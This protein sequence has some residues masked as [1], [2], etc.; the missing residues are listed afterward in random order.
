MRN[1]GLMYDPKKEEINGIPEEMEFLPA[2]NQKKLEKRSPKERMLLVGVIIGAALLSLVTGLLVWHFHFRP[3][4]RIK[5]MYN[6]YLTIA[7]KQFTEE[8]EDSESA[9]FKKLAAT[10][11]KTLQNT[12]MEMDSVA[13]Y[14][15][16]STVTAFSEGSVIAYY[17]LECRV[18]PENADE[19]DKAIRATSQSISGRSYSGVSKSL[20]IAELVV[21]RADPQ[22]VKPPKDK[23]CFFDLHAFPEEVSTFTSPGFPNS[24][25]PANSWCQWVIRADPNHILELKFVTFDLENICHNDFVVVYDSLSPIEKREITERCGVYPPTNALKLISSRNVMLVTLM[26]DDDENYPGFK[27][28]F[29]QLP[30]RGECNEILEGSGNISSPYYPAYYPPRADCTWTLRVPSNKHVKVIFEVFLLQ[31]PDKD[32]TCKDYVEI[33]GKK[34]CGEKPKMVELGNKNE[35]TVR[36]RSDA[37]GSFRGFFA[38]F[39]PHDPSKPCPK[40]FACNNGQCIQLDLKCDGWNDCGDNSDEIGCVCT[41]EQFLCGTGLCK[42]K[43]WVCDGVNDCGDN[44]DEANCECEADEMKCSNGKCI[45]EVQKCN[46]VHECGDGSDEKDCNNAD[47]STVVCTEHTYKCSDGSCIRKKNPECDGTK[48]CADGSDEKN[49][50]CGSRPYKHSRIVGGMDAE[51]GEWPWQVSLHFKDHRSTCGASVISKSWLVSASHCFQDV[52]GVRYSD[53]GNWMAYLGLHIQHQLNDRVVKRNIKRIIV[54]EHY[55]PQIFDNDIA[56]LEL[57]QPVSFTSVIQPVCLPDASHN[58]PV[59]KST[60]VTG[61]G[62]TSENGAGATVLQKAEIRIINRA[63]CNN[64]MS[65]SVTSRML[66]A[67]YLSGGIDACQGAYVDLYCWE[68]LLHHQLHPNNNMQTSLWIHKLQNNKKG[69]GPEAKVWAPCMVFPYSLLAIGMTMYLPTLIWKVFVTP[70]LTADLLFIIDELDKAYN[71]SIKVVQLILKKYEN[72]PNAKSLIQE[73]LDRSLSNKRSVKLDLQW[74][75]E[76]FKLLRERQQQP[77]TGYNN[78]SHYFSNMDL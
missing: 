70:I 72:N 58:F 62:A 3:D 36:F 63:V 38:T 61:W 67:G 37:A 9:A 56:L 11:E 42:S 41:S 59:G 14:Y 33:N 23:S 46:L 25:Y 13:P 7:N 10:V 66:C 21:D 77:V 35:M 69:K 22:K 30:K 64:L 53:P 47:E 43:F 60:W 51:I 27:A 34:I 45:P 24:P 40:E 32:N 18:P 2:S 39:E 4:N 8:L 54:H 31:N 65:S 17:W 73:E 6:G 50:A 49:C 75:S 76:L 5:K 48:H 20:R 57:A 71:R 26:T 68:T 19:L 28:E 15:V 12:Y 16:R 44:S 52:Q 1:S 29:R 78:L 55:N 74:T